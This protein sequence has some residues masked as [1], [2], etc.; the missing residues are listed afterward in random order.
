MTPFRETRGF[1]LLPVVL[2]L[3][4]LAAVAF[5]LNRAN[6]FSLRMVADQSDME[7]ARY[8]AEA[9]LQAV[10]FVVQQAGCSGTYPTAAAPVTNADFAGAAYSAYSMAATG[11][12]VRL[13]ST[14][15]Y[16]GASVTL[17]RNQ[18]H[19]YQARQTRVIQP[20]QNASQDTY[21]DSSQE[22]NFGSDTR[23][24]FQTGRYSPLV[25]ISL[26]ELPA[27]SRAV[28]WYDAANARLQ[29]GAVLSLYQNDVSSSGTGSLTLHARPI[30]RTWL[31][32][33]RNGGGVPDGATWLTYDGV[34]PGP[35]PGAGYGP[36]PVAVVPYTGA[37][38][39]V[40]W[41]LSAAV[42]AW[43]SG[44]YP[45]NGVWIKESG[46]SIG[47][48]S[49]V[50]ANDNANATL[51][52][53]LTLSVLQ[54]CGSSGTAVIALGADAYLRSGSEASRNYGGALLTSINQGSPERRI[55]LRFDVSTVPPGS[56]VKSA[57]L[58]LYCRSVLNATIQSKRINAYYV[59]EP[60]TEGTLN[61]SGTANGATWSTRDGASAWSAAG[62]YAHWSS[63]LGTARDEATGNAPLPGGFRSGWVAFD[64]T[65]M[66][67]AWVD[68][69]YANYGILLRSESSS[70]LFEFDSRESTS[71]TA[72]QLVVIYQ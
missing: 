24:R 71:G 52:P 32:G 46:G 13:V 4:V 3:G 72:P 31:A 7:R 1:T 43:L 30:T 11:S 62:G 51:R 25:K 66:V 65:G 56:A 12:P 63:V 49:F 55:V 57:V 15:T 17:T 60:W 39:W 58:R 42:A 29:P 69:A 38:G 48:T 36:T 27:G 19:V 34:N 6:G 10:N 59:M 53:K 54:P 23:L 26:S 40:D 41:D 5:M 37:I 70:D 33:N 18:V 47:N 50:S 9:G 14:G 2:A 16:K 67:Q 35:A 22:R 61:G 64:L 45:N 68:N 20:P 28:P 21:I 44:V 8:A